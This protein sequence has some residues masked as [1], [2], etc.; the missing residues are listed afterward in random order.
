MRHCARRRY[1]GHLPYIVWESTDITAHAE[2]TA[3]RVACKSLGQVLLDGC[4]VATTCEPCP[5]CMSALHWA[6]VDKVYFGATIQDAAEA[7]FNEL[8]LP[9]K[10]VIRLGG[11]SIVLVPDLMRH[12]CADLFRSWRAQASHPY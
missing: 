11:S 3:I 9:A 5:M 4:T 1:P 2:V 10:D 7:G 8:T 12:E 6:R